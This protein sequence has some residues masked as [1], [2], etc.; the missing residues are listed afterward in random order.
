[1]AGDEA[2]N[3]GVIYLEDELYEFQTKEG[4]RTWSVFGSPVGS[5]TMSLTLTD[6]NERM[7]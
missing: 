3:A 2:R 4:G 1:M 6:G 7:V 5:M